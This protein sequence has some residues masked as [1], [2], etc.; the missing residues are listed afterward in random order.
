MGDRFSTE[1]PRIA[2]IVPQVPRV[3]RLTNIFPRLLQ[4]VM[5]PGIT[6]DA[7]NC[8]KGRIGVRNVGPQPGM[9]LFCHLGT[10]PLCLLAAGPVESRLH[11]VRLPWC[12]AAHKGSIILASIPR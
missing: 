4:I 7:H 9:T 5:L 6:R 1:S 11:D 8:E 2:I 12:L 3:G 10:E